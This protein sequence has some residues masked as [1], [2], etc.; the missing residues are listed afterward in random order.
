M[1]QD[2]V[3]QD[4][5]DELLGGEGAAAALPPALIPVVGTL[6]SSLDLPPDWN[7]SP[8]ANLQAG[9]ANN[10]PTLPPSLGSVSGR[11]TSASGH[12][13]PGRPQVPQPRGR[14]AANGQSQ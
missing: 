2:A 11:L 8:M 1:P 7:T 3:A 9:V 10:P 6:E 4:V 5:V 12:T 14:G 13:P